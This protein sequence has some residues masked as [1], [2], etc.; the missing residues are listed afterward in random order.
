MLLS[1]DP[2]ELRLSR[3]KTARLRHAWAKGQIE[4]GGPTPALAKYLEESFQELAALL[5]TSP[6][7]NKKYLTQPEEESAAAR[8]DPAN[9]ARAASKRD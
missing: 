6:R 8:V 4:K 5:A 3:I 9:T 2:H 1:L 7:K